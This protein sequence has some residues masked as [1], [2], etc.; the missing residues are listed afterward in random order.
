LP[1][2]E[3]PSARAGSCADVSERALERARK[4]FEQGFTD[5]EW[6]C[7]HEHFTLTAAGGRDVAVLEHARGKHGGFARTLAEI[8]GHHQTRAPHRKEREAREAPSKE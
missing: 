7:E 1:H 3:H 2:A 5:R 4:A 6:W 8:D